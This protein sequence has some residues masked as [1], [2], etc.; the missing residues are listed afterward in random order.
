MA[1]IL[2]MQ[3]KIWA[4]FEEDER[5]V[6]LERVIYNMVNNMTKISSFYYNAMKS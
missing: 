2:D 5:L 3:L 4:A 1:H 6:T